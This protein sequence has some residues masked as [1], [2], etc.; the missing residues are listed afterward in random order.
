MILYAFEGLGA[1]VAPLAATN[2][3]TQGK[4]YFHYLI[5]SGIAI[6]NTVALAYIFR[7]KSQDSKS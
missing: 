4:W 7:L 1:F 3:A 2:F 6:S 5:S